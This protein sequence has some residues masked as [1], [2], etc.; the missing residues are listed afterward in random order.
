MISERNL[1]LLIYKSSEDNE[2]Y[3]HVTQFESVPEKGIDTN[4]GFQAANRNREKS[5]PIIS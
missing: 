4:L 1:I 5:N 3:Y 2:K